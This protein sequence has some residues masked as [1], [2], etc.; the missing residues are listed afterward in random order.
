MA[1]G[2]AFVTGLLQGSIDKRQAA[3]QAAQD[4]KEAEAAAAAR[5]AEREGG[6]VQVRRRRPLQPARRRP[7]PR[8]VGQRGGRRQEFAGVRRDRVREA[9]DARRVAPAHRAVSG[10]EVERH[11]FFRKATRRHQKR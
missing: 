6:A 2:V 3:I 10:R 9:L 7:L 8:L 11:V 4:Q 5:R 1:M